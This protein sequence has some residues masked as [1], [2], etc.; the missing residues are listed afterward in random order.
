MDMLFDKLKSVITLFN[1][2]DG[3]WLILL[4]KV[5]SPILNLQEGTPS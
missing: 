3:Q 5:V 1:A 4:K 2:A